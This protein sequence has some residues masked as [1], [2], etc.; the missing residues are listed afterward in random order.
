MS[1]WISFA[2]CSEGGECEGV[3][4]LLIFVGLFV[5]FVLFLA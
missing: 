1:I 4:R 3:E 2:L 5:A